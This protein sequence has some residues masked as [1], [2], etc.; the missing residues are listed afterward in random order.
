M[1]CKHEFVVDDGEYVCQSCGIIGDR[2]ID[3]AAEW[4]NYEGK[5]ES[6]RAGF[7]T[8]DLLPESSY[9]SIISFRGISSTNTK[10]KSLQRLST[11]SVSSNSEQALSY[12]AEV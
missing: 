11:W 6:S 12:L 8:S 5:D 3:E 10:M 9:G 2:M 4:R 1:E 7:T